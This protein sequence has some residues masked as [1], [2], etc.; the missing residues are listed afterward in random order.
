VG[1][2]RVRGHDAQVAA[3]QR[4][5]QRGR[6]GHAYLF[7]GPAGVGKHL[8]GK[9][10]AKALLCEAH[11]SG[12]DVPLAACDACP[13]C[14]QVEAGTHP[15]FFA[16]AR[17]P[18]NAEFPVALM[19]ELCHGFS[20]KPARGRGKVILIDGADDFN[21]ESANCFLKTLEEPP[22]A[23]VLILIGSSSDRQLPTVVS[24]CQVIR[25][26]P[27]PDDLV[28][29]L[30][31]AQGIDEAQVPRLVRLG[32]GSPGLALAL[33]DPELWEF[34]RE[35]LEGL[36]RPRFDP[37]ALASALRTFCEKAGKESAAQRRRARL[38]LRLLLDFLGDALALRVEAAPRRTDEADRPALDA[39]LSRADADALLACLE[40]CLEADE[41]VERRVQLV[42]TLEA[43]FDA[44]AQRLRGPLRP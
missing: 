19:Q 16:A 30:L 13:A 40:R 3:F 39:L 14:V 38:V 20:L 26:A 8:F 1:W 18:E 15:D 33:A 36:S 21:E 34:R 27:L 4:A 25:F 9:E 24:R 41:E 44:L 12:A 5:R 23:S 7:T 22:P 11:S 35:L 6:L 42:L 37:G 29:E 28:A 2:Q 10:L 32:A 43:L 31:R 17:P